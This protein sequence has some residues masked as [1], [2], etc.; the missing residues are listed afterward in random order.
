MGYTRYLIFVCTNFQ[1]C[2]P[3]WGRTKDTDEHM[4]WI[5]PASNEEEPGAEPDTLNG[6]KSVRELYEIAS[7]S[8]SG[9]YTVPVCA[10]SDGKRYL[11]KYGII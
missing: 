1:S 9:K 4:G 8:Y 11:S 7:S 10:G 3:I 6:A 2:K 5:F